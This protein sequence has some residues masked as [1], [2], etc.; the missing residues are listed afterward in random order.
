M[1]GKDQW[2]AVI[3][4]G[5]QGIG[6]GLVARSFFRRVASSIASAATFRA[7]RRVMH[8]LAARPDQ[9]AVPLGRAG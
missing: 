9:D 7:P 4:G 1:T 2:V 3:T 6:A 5:S 8:L